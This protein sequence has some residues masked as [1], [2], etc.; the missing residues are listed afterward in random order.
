MQIAVAGV[1]SPIEVVV[2]EDLPHEMILGNTSLRQGRGIIDLA[3]N[4]LTWFN[5]KGPLRG[6][7]KQ[8]YSSIGP[9]VPETG[10]AR[11]NKLIQRNADVFSAKGEQNGECQTSAL[12]IKTVG[13]PICQ[14]AYRMPLNKRE[15]VEVT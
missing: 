8:G 4:E 12:H 10:N 7:G 13:P 5:Q 2:C 6:Y 15:V 9:I 1:A 11:M 3:K 14:K